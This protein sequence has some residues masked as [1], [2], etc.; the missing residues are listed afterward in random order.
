MTYQ[1]EK[2]SDGVSEILWL[3][4][5]SQSCGP[6]CVFMIECMR[7]QACLVGGEERVR[8]IMSL[9]PQGYTE[10]N[11][12][13]AYTALAAA[14]VQA[15]VTAKAIFTGTVP[16][17]F[18]SAKYPFIARIGW[19]NGGG[20][21]IVCAKKTRGG[22]IVCLDP[23]YGLNE[24]AAKALPAYSAGNDVRQQMCLVTPVGGTFSG[25]FITM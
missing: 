25:H 13:A 9:L 20:H 14:L 16:S 15:G 1:V 2:D 3:Q 6:A 23:W 18:A 21:F 4:E 22:A 11:G 5:R 12:T 17:F 7:A 8:R 19:P 24:T 10:N